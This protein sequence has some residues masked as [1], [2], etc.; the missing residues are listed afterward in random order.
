MAQT[1]PQPI[2]D[3]E[4]QGPAV[5]GPTHVQDRIISPVAGAKTGWRNL[6][7]IEIAYRRGKFGAMDSQMARLRR[8]AG[9]EFSD[10]WDSREASGRDST[11]ALN[12]SRS[13][14]G[15]LPI[16]LRQMQAMERLKKIKG[17]VGARSY[18]ILRAFCGEGMLPSEAIK[19]AGCHEDTRVV[20]RLCDA[21]DELIVALG[22][23]VRAL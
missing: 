21:L 14:G 11:Q 3:D 19:L 15:G 12:G 7:V 4:V 8:D 22:W 5:I 16:S 18:I 23:Q 6:S 13:S 17:D 1:N 2:E 9:L 20:A 10:L